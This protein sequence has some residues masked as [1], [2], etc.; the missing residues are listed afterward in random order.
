MPNLMDEYEEVWRKH[1]E[2]GRQE[3]W[4]KD[5]WVNRL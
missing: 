2:E 5:E 4:D 1:V 3:K